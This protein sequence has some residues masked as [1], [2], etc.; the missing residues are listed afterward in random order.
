MRAM[1][2]LM[3]GCAGVTVLRHHLAP[4]T[5]QGDDDLLT[6]LPRAEQHHA[7]GPRTQ[8]WSYFHASPN[9]KRPLATAGGKHATAALLR[10][11]LQWGDRAGARRRARPLSRRVAT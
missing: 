2:Y 11:D 5:L 10:D 3:S 6:Q 1:L 8:R 7:R 4:E 9:K